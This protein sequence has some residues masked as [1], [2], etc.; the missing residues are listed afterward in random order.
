MTVLF[1]FMNLPDFI[2]NNKHPSVN[3]FSCKKE[4]ICSGFLE[5]AYVLRKS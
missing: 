1:V 2:K 4:Q 5:A 3:T